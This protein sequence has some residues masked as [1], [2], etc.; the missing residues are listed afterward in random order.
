MPCATFNPVCRELGAPPLQGRVTSCGWSFNPVCRELGAPPAM[1]WPLRVTSRSFNPVCRELGAPP[2]TRF[3]LTSEGS[4]GFQSRL[5]GVG[6]SAGAARSGSCRGY[7][8]QSRLPGVGG[9]AG[10]RP[11][12]LAMRATFNP[13]CRELGAPP[14]PAQLG[15][16]QP[17]LSIPFAGSWGLRP[18]K[19]GLVVF[20]WITTFNPVCRE[21]GAPPFV[22]GVPI[23]STVLSI[24]FAGSWGLRLRG[25][26]AGLLLRPLSIPF[27]GSW[28]LRRAPRVE[29][30]V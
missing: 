9:S 30:R 1:H 6:G 27:A 21:L 28:G 29:S 26:A 18:G 20:I 16:H 10:G 24:P 22:A 23:Q 14:A 12:R 25:R 4:G 11:S 7:R 5:P 3:P 17:P 15:K 2:R 8:F 13:V 19:E